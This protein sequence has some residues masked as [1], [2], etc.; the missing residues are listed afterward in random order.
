M[1]TN[2]MTYLVQCRAWCCM[3]LYSPEVYHALGVRLR[4]TATPIG[5]LILNG[6]AK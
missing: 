3:F 5:I 4:I 6:I 2:Y 1:S